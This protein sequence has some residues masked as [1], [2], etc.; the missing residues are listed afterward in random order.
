MA[1][2]LINGAPFLFVIS[3]AYTFERAW[4]PKCVRT[5]GFEPCWLQYPEAADL[6]LSLGATR[7][8]GKFFHQKK[9]AVGTN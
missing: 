2:R 9:E 6:P 8:A 1:C 7:F 4:I 5:Y 3:F